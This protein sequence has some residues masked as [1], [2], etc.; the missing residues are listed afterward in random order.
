MAI[1]ERDGLLGE[2]PTASDAFISECAELQIFADEEAYRRGYQQGLAAYCTPSGGFDAG[3]QGLDYDGICP[4][5]VER[6]FLE[7]YYLGARLFELTNDYD[8][9]V[10][11]YKDA[12]DRINKHD[13]NLTISQNRY[14]DA[15]IAN[16]D[17]EIARQDIEYNRREIAKWRQELPL[18][19]VEIDRAR[20]RLEDYR[21]ELARIRD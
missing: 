13:Y 10:K 16:E 6:A 11:R 8:R 5:D 20:D 15:N 1:G 19:N 17:R 4:A 9:A 3:K 18:L 21:R 2:R 7:E 14:R 12:V